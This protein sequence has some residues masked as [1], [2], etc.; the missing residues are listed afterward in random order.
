MLIDILLNAKVMIIVGVVSGILIKLSNP[1]IPLIDCIGVFLM[2]SIISW[3]FFGSIV[4][5]LFGYE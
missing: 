2:A 4:I 1:M 5:S 3:L